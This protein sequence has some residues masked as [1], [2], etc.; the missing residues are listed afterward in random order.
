MIALALLLSAQAQLVPLTPPDEAQRT[1]GFAYRLLED[2]DPYRA[3]TELKRFAYQ[4]PGSADVFPAYLAVARAYEAGGKAG[5]ATAWLSHL[6]AYAGTL[7]LRADLAVELA[8]A[9][10]LSGQTQDA[11]QDLGE[12]LADPKGAGAASLATRHRATYLLGWSELLTHRPHEAAELFE[13]LPLPYAHA[14]SEGALSLTHLPSK[15]P[16]L[17]GLLSALVPGLGHVYLGQPLI[18]LSAF[19]WNALFIAAT[20]DTLRR[21]LWGVSAVLGFLELLWYGGAVYGAV[22]GA[23]KYNRD[24]ELNQIDELKARFDPAPTSWPP[25]PAAR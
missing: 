9:R 1:Q 25:A 16:W 23:N 20:A 17:A 5:D 24:A 4:A 3:I 7:E 22:S 12:F 14:L 13:R 2:G 10:Y 15:S 19:G 21:Q 18:G 6:D 8:Y 11:A